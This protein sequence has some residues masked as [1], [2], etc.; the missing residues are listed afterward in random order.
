MALLFCILLLVKKGLGVEEEV[1]CGG[2]G[3]I[4]NDNGGQER[5]YKGLKMVGNERK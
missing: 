1:K 2:G 4:R 3:E 5:E